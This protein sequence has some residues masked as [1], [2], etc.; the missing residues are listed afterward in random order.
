MQISKS[1]RHSKITGDF[2]ERLV[3][4]WLSKYGF[5]CAFVDHVGLDIIARNPHTREVMGISV[6]SRSRNTGT[7]GTYIGIPNDQLT[8]LDAACA[9]FGCIPYFAIVA[10]EADSIVVFILSQEHLVR[11]CPPGKEMVVWKMRPSAVQAYECDPNIR[12]F[13]FVTKT[14]NWWQSEQN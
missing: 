8:K 7:E 4:Y 5:E 2:A 1:S 14:G 12:A 13:R 6:K 11:V 3:L 9:G 10:D